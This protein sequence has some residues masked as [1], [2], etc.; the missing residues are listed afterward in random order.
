LPTDEHEIVNRPS[1]RV[2]RIFAK[3]NV[4]VRD[5][6][7][8][9]RVGDRVEW[10]GINEVLRVRHPDAIAKVRHETCARLDLIPL[11][12]ELLAAPLAEQVKTLPCHAHPADSQ[13]HT[14]LFDGS[15]DVV[16]LSLQADVLNS[17][18]RHRRDGWLLLPDG[19]SGWDARSKDWLRSECENAG[20]A[21]L[22]TTLRS[23]RRLVPVIEQRLGAHVLVYNLSPLIPGEWIH[24][25]AGAEDSLGLRVR[26]FNLALAELSAELGFSIVDVERIVAS[27]GV[28]IKIDLPHLNAEG[29]RLVA[30][31][32]VRILE[33]RCVFDAQ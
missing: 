23:L 31:E 13:H 29:W 27:T 12:G 2:V 7:L 10:N 18:V 3:G 24:C 9:S 8:F 1:R 22:E 21:A 16:V 5:S 26:R 15:S 17:L 25:W 33:D 19:Y 20:L 14:A 4:D 28:R 6:L 32:V 11:P 30:E